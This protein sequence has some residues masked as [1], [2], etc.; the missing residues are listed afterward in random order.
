VTQDQKDRGAPLDVVDDAT[1]SRSVSPPVDDTDWLKTAAIIFVAIGHVGYFFV[2]DARWWSVIGRLA[3]PTFFFLIGYARSR[4]VPLSWILLGVVLSVLESWNA[5]WDWVAPNILLSFAVV[6]LA[7][8]HIERFAERYGWV[9]FVVLT[10]GLVAVLPLAAKCFDYGSE[11]WLW[12]LFG[13]YQR[14]YVDGKAAASLPD[15]TSAPAQ[16]GWTR[17]NAKLIRL[18]ACA[19]AAPVFVWQEQKEFSFPPLPL[20]VVVLEIVALS[21][22]LCVFR[23]RPSRLQ[24]PASAAAVVRFIGR[25]TLLIYALQL[26]GS[27]LLVRVLPDDD[28]DQEDSLALPAVAPPPDRAQVGSVEPPAVA[29]DQSQRPQRL[30]PSDPE[31]NFEALWKT[32]NNRYPFFELRKVDWNKQY[33]IY[34]PQV[35]P[36]TSDEQLFDVMRRMLD[37]LDDGHV[38]LKAKL[39][40]HR[41]PRRFTAEKM[42]AFQR[43]FS[44]GGTKQ[45]FATTA[46]TLV[47]HGFG[48]PEQTAAWMLHY[49]RSQEFG[50]I[51]ILE[52]EGIGM[53]TLN[54]AL[55]KIARDFDGLKGFIID[56]RDNPGG[57]DSTAIAIINRFCDR[58]RVAFRRKT[59]I[60]PGKDAF[61]PVTTWHLEPQGDAQFV[62]PIVLLTS[63][64]VF[65]GGEA[66][67]LAIRQLPYVT[68]VGDHTNGIFSYQLEKK[69]PNG[70]EYCLSYQVYMSADHVC[71]EGKGVPA[72]IELLNTKAD[73]ARGV[74]PLI[75]RALEI[76]KG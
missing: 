43:E 12:A 37:P 17:P 72:D 26:A 28:D 73:I 55:D 70:W 34:R 45:L 67:A 10:A 50:Y 51:R 14:R 22:C 63:D 39:S 62:G 76:L 4:T 75:T 38:E 48:K 61:T 57:D 56:I 19:V 27:E 9:A 65:S 42:T 46:K 59:K 52:L 66:F 53:H 32:F 49:A 18:A 54:R 6:R 33:E 21:V 20:T 74:D 36:E 16:S 40:G 24:P 60:G 58:K 15:G 47:G 68:I 8:P 41:Q 71:Y 1:R 23:R 3:A 25:R 29:R 31:K 13:L 64:S 11:G 5:D 35:T 44:G 30:M 2:D 7:R 69:L